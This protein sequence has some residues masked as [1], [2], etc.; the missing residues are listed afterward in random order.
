[1]EGAFALTRT[2]A[3]P[4]LAAQ[5]RAKRGSAIASEGSIRQSAGQSLERS[6][7]QI[8]L[9]RQIGVP[10]I[11]VFMTKGRCLRRQALNVFELE[12]RSFAIEETDP[13][14]RL[15]GSTSNTT[16]ARGAV[17]SG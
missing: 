12:G 6:L 10:C 7:E 5:R 17:A 15:I 9:A 11:I 8:L 16:A 14:A 2:A 13:A 4:L 3:L 1:M